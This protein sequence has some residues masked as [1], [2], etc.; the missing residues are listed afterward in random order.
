MAVLHHRSHVPQDRFSTCV[1]GNAGSGIGS[2]ATTLASITTIAGR[3]SGATAAAISTCHVRAST[4]TTASGWSIITRVREM[5]SNKELQDMQRQF[6]S[7]GSHSSWVYCQE[8]EPPVHLQ[9]HAQFCHPFKYINHVIYAAQR[10]IFHLYPLQLVVRLLNQPLQH[11]VFPADTAWCNQPLQHGLIAIPPLSLDS[12]PITRYL[13][14]Q[15]A[16]FSMALAILVLTIP[17]SS[18]LFDPTATLIT[19]TPLPHVHYC[20][21]SLYL[22]VLLHQNAADWVACHSAPPPPPLHSWWNISYARPAQ[23]PMKEK[24]IPMHSHIFLL[25]SSPPYIPAP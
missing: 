16:L 12:N 11:G 17:W 22:P 5:G 20:N 18:N 19:A 6:S 2:A 15:H 8:H 23:Q 3:T 9:A 7:M 21:D 25:M 10:K 24:A 13:H 14:F 1:A 4:T